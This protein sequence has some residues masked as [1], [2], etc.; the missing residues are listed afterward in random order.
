MS[1]RERTAVLQAV[2][3]RPLED[4]E[5][6]QAVLGDV[7]LKYADAVDA[8]LGEA[9]VPGRRE[10]GS[11][12]F[13]KSGS[14]ETRSEKTPLLSAQSEAEEKF[15][16]SQK[17]E[18]P[19]LPALKA[20]KKSPLFLPKPYVD[21]SG[22]IVVV[23]E[24]PDN[25]FSGNRFEIHEAVLSHE[26]F[27]GDKP[28]R[29]WIAARPSLQGVQGSS[30]FF[31]RLRPKEVAMAAVFCRTFLSCAFAEARWHGRNRGHLCH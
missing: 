1:T 3:L 19:L 26:F 16:R 28:G 10:F 11:R 2:G 30:L 12:F 27:K 5:G 14:S 7:E 6:V 15:F 31:R 18:T 22:R 21:I 24:Q 13:T 20:E 29:K 9:T 17:F 8:V 23:E 4:V 25:D